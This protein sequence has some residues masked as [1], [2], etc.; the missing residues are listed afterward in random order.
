MTTL[1]PE[2]EA[3]V[4]AYYAGRNSID[5]DGRCMHTCSE[6]KQN[7]IEAWRR[8][9]R[10]VRSELRLNADTEWDYEPAWYPN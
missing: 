6:T 2:K 8:G 7:L 1:T 4:N 3:E 10:N 9:V 5:D